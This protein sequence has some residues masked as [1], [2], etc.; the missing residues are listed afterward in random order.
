V[1]QQPEILYFTTLCFTFGNAAMN[2][3]IFTGL[4]GAG[5]STVGRLLARRRRMAFFDSDRVI[6]ECMGVSIPTIFE[7]EGEAGFRDREQEVIKDLASRSNII[8]ATGGGSLLREENRQCLSTSGII[9]YLRASPEHLY[10]RIQHDK[11][12]PLMQTKNPLQT[13][14]NILRKREQAYMETADVIITTGR[15]RVI[16]TVRQIERALEQLIEIKP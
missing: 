2:N 15:D 1:S 11:N 14:K 12:R 4:M 6:E 3:V 10:A 13:L 7:I 8:I 16:M 5:K 9:V